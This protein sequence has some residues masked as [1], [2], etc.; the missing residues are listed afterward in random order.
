M[1][2]TTMVEL[3]TIEAA[4]YRQKLRGGH[5]GVVILRYDTEQPGIATLNR[6]SGEPDPSHHTDTTLFPLEAFKE[7]LELTS[8]MP[9]SRRGKVKLSGVK[10]EESSQEETAEELAT[11]D[12][13]EYEAIVKTYTNRKGEL[14]YELLNKD[15]IQFAKGSKVVSDMVANHASQDEI[16][17]HVIKVKLEGITGNR[18]LTEAQT[19]RIVDM[20]DEVSPRHVFKELN[21]EIRKMLANR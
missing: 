4:A 9:Y 11:V 8:G 7:A 12:S 13:A 21:D 15:F 17:Q 10:E 16:R 18:E 20:L 19:Q 5:S 2:R 14:S 3:S 1:I 6:K